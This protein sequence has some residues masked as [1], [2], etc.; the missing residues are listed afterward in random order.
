MNNCGKCKFFNNSRCFATKSAIKV[1]E[2]NC[3]DWFMPV[4]CCSN[5]IHGN[6]I[7]GDEECKYCTLNPINRN[8]FI[9]DETRGNV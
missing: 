2:T 3:C 9:Y 7:S 8:H 5:C 1:S 6:G 4:A